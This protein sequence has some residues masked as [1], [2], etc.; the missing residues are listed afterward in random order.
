MQVRVGYGKRIQMLPSS[1]NIARLWARPWHQDRQLTFLAHYL[2]PGMTVLDIGAESGLYALAAA[3]W[4]GHGT[5]Y[6]LEPSGAR[7]ECLERNIALNRAVNITA[8]RTTLGDAA[9]ERELCT[10]CMP[11][12]HE[13]ATLAC[14]DGLHGHVRT[15]ETVAT[16]PLDIYLSEQSI[17]HVDL[18]RL[19]VSGAELQVLNGA[20]ELLAADSG[21]AVVYRSSERNTASFAYHPVEIMW[22]LQDLGYTLST[23]D[24]RGKLQLRSADNEYSGIFVAIKESCGR[25]CELL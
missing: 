10:V 3:K 6:A 19:S 17:D 9:G 11:T 5:V 16:V 13:R 20:R 7:F 4:V 18:M 12:N 14:T 8:Q 2:K 22:L 25:L 23:I 15:R 24:R 21:P 1:I